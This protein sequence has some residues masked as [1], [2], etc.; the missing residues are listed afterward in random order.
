MNKNIIAI[1]GLASTGKSAIAKKLSLHLNIPYANS[2]ALFRGITYFA[3]ENGFIKKN[4]INEK[5]LK[6]SLNNVRLIFNS[7]E[8]SIIL[9]DKNISQKL[10][11]NDISS[12]VSQIAKLKFVRSF[13]MDHQRIMAKN[14]G[15]IIEG[16]DIGTVVFP[17]ANF[18][19]FFTASPEVR[20][21]RRLKQMKGIGLKSSYEEVLSNLISRDKMDTE[22]ELSPLIKAEDAFEIDTTS[23]SADEVLAIL[24]NI[25]NSK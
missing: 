7:L 2:G 10:H 24:L 19:F 13:L 11:S 22:R 12:F 8:N 20:A 6:K 18:K 16:R 3:L 25:I 5:S 14:K 21:E 1:D 17:N 9:N 15:L 4:Y 23:I